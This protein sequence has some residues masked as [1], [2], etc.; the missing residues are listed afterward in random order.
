MLTPTFDVFSGRYR[1]AGANWIDAVDG[2]EEA[3][4]MML[5]LAAIKPG[6]YFI[7]DSRDQSCAGNVDSTYIN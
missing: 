1:E 6:P 7:F 4:K 3:Y 2:F 5:M